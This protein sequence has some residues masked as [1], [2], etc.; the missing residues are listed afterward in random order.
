MKVFH[1]YFFAFAAYVGAAIMFG[2]CSDP[3]EPPLPDFERKSFSSTN[4]ELYYN[5]ELMPGKTAEVAIADGEATVRFYSTF[6][7]SQ[8]QGL[9]LDSKIECPGVVPGSQELTLRA[10]ANPGNGCYVVEGKNETQ[11]AEF[12]YS[13]AIYSDKMTFRFDDCRLKNQNLAGKVFSPAPIEMD[14]LQV[15]SLPFHLVWEIDPAAVIDIPLSGILRNIAVLPIIPVYGSTAYMSVA[16]A[17]ESTLKTIALTSSGNVPV[18]YVSQVGGAAHLATTSGNM[19]QYVPTED[20]IKLY[21]NP[22][23][24]FSQILVATSDNKDN[25]QFDFAE[26]LGRA[27][28][29]GSTGLLPGDIKKIV[30]K[31]LLEA[32]TPQIA[33]GI[34]LKIM[35]TEKGADIYFDTATSVS[36]LANLLEDILSNPEIVGAIQTQLASMSLPGLTPEQFQEILAGMPTFLER[37]TKL[38]IG[39][40]LIGVKQE[41]QPQER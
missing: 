4:L 14:G 26:M 15:K 17:V 27:G 12:A 25:Y 34:S 1:R 23:S 13:G 2:G 19:L 10:A 39:L 16:Q 38:E 22:L 28:D 31:S 8:V 5:G 3:K 18:V 30:L 7:L 6:D 24:L 32:I 20:G 37:T 21:I 40:C 11:D 33:D 9:G 35:P 29:A 36:F 41:P